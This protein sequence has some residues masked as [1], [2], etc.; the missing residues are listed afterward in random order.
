MS[1]PRLVAI[2]STVAAS[3][4]AFF[5]VTRW[6]L[7]GTLAGAAL[8]PLVHTLV[9]HWSNRGIDRSIALVRRRATK[10]QGP[11]EDTRVYQGGSGACPEG[12][13]GVSSGVSAI[14][15]ILVGLTCLALALGIY[16]AA[17][18][19]PADR[20]I[21][22]ERVIERQVAA[23]AQIPVAPEGSGASSPITDTATSPTTLPADGDET[24]LGAS[25]G[26]TAGPGTTANPSETTVTSG[27]SNPSVP[28]APEAGIS[29]GSTAGPGST[30]TSAAPVAEVAP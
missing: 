30:S 17:F 19:T 22:N 6:R 8:I 18:K 2:L 11:T 9:S 25:P 28:L 23:A 1:H 24:D 14:P 27:G 7:A 13:P 29:P 10:R 16:S 12:C 3:M 15:W 20:V 26:T 5:V 4:V 21:V